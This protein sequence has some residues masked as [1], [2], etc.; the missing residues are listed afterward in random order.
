M[1]QA[2]TWIVGSTAL[3]L[4]WLGTAGAADLDCPAPG[5]FEVDTDA[6]AQLVANGFNCP[7]VDLV[8]K[9]S[10]S[11]PGP[12]IPVQKLNI[13]AKS[14]TCESPS[15]VDPTQRLQIVNDLAVSELVITALAGNIK[16]NN[17]ALKAH[18]LLRFTCPSPGCE[19]EADFSEIVAATDFANPDAGG[20][21]FFSI[22]GPI[23]IRTTV[24]H[25][26]DTVEVKSIDSSVT[27]LCT[28]SEGVCKS[29]LDVPIPAIILAQCPP[30]PGDPPGTLIHFPCKL[31]LPDAAALVG[32]CF[33][34][35][36]V[37]CNGGHKEKRFTAGTF[38]DLTGSFIT[39][40]EHVTFT[41]GTADPAQGH[42][43]ASGATFLFDSLFVKCSGTID[44]SNATLDMVKNLNMGNVGGQCPAGALC[45]NASGATINAKPLIITANGAQ[46]V[47]DVCG[48]TFTTTPGTTFP[49]LNNDT[50][51]SYDTNVLDTTA[52]CGAKPTPQAAA[53]FVNSNG[54]TTCIS[55][56]NCTT[57]P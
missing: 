17:C 45:V 35:V 8:L 16:V 54:T 2:W 3:L 12:G 28:G 4:V 57:T 9:M 46:S 39:S 56:G 37:T 7:N 25:G 20:G 29:P 55:N 21:L 13:E 18:K 1:R 48:G 44:I 32:V 31:K 50:T 15:L 11:S 33:P 19:F 53:K 26:G 42:L 36:Q 6:E 14:F 23:D 41:C 38:L 40:D 34:E 24:L 51:P 30:Q 47:I 43:K 10:L 49:K 52:E 27:I 5:V 22:R